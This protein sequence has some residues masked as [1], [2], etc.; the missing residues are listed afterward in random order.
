MQLFCFLKLD[1]D[2]GLLYGGGR[3]GRVGA[4]AIADRIG[5]EVLLWGGGGHDDTDGVP[6]LLNLSTHVCTD[7]Q[8]KLIIPI[9]PLVLI[10][11]VASRLARWWTFTRCWSCTLSGHCGRCSST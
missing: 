6:V 5:C 1:D 3:G 4:G 11:F 8:N 7:M 2:G 10:I 9:L